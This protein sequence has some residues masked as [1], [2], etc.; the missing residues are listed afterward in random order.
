MAL[1]IGVMTGS[2]REGSYNRQ[3]GALAIRHLRGRGH[4]VTEID[5]ADYPMPIY[6]ARIEAEAF[7]P[8]ALELKT[9]LAGLDALVIACPE[10]NGSLPALVK[11]TI[12]WTSRPTGGESPFALSAWR[13][14]PIAIMSASPGMAGGMRSLAHLRQILT[15][16]QALVI[17]QQLTLPAA[18]SGL[19]D[20]ELTDPLPAGLLADM[21]DQLGL[22]AAALAAA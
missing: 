17:P 3:L 1:N 8:K 10:Y 16:I 19:I 7:P 6:E 12:D 15:L 14:K 20:G 4:G 21:L 11:N 18:H 9:L 5:L 13:G 22:L 2:L